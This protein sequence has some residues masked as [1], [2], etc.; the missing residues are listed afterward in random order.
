MD[1]ILS[2]IFHILVIDISTFVRMQTLYSP[3]AD[4][5]GSYKSPFRSQSTAQ[6]G[7]Y[8]A[9]SSSSASNKSVYDFHLENSSTLHVKTHHLALRIIAIGIAII[10]RIQEILNPK[11]VIHSFWLISV[12]A[13]DE[14]NSWECIPVRDLTSKTNFKSAIQSFPLP[15]KANDI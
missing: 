12:S 3:A 7:I 15:G 6:Q 5:T 1:D 11:D 9:C 4:L 8:T 14:P 13:S 10:T 2:C